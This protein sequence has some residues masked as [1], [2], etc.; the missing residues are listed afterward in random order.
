MHQHGVTHPFLV[1]IGLRLL[2]LHIRNGKSRGPANGEKLIV[3]L[4]NRPWKRIEQLAFF[5]WM[6]TCCILM[7]LVG[8]KKPNVYSN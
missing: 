5:V 4:S 8:V 2:L 6:L 1:V 7:M 3:F